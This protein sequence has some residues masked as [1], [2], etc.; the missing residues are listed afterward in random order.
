MNDNGTFTVLA[1]ALNLPT[2]LHF[3]GD[4]A[5]IVTLTGEVWKINGVSNRGG[6]QRDDD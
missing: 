1:D 3:A 4:A 6:H 2:S 5:L